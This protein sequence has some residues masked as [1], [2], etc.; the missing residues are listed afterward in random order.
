VHLV[1]FVLDRC[2]VAPYRLHLIYHPSQPLIVDPLDDP[3]SSSVLTLNDISIVTDASLD[4]LLV[5][6]VA[7]QD[8]TQREFL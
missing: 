5:D 6:V 2:P 3:R 4:K 8:R 1:N 7:V